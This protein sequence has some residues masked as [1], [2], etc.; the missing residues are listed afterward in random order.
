MCRLL[1]DS[2]TWRKNTQQDWSYELAN[3]H[4]HGQVSFASGDVIP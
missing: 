4:A 1:K 3:Q 2:T